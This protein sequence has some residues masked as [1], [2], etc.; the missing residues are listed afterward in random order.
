MVYFNFDRAQIWRIRLI[1]TDSVL[2]FEPAARKTARENF[3]RS[4]LS[5]LTQQIKI[6]NFDAYQNS[7]LC[8]NDNWIGST[9]VYFD[10]D[11]V[12][13]A[14]AY[15]GAAQILEFAQNADYELLKM[16]VDK[17]VKKTAKQ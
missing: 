2:I 15:R 7:P 12:L 17:L 10:K 14:E 4:E 9:S 13:I 11:K 5:L 1:Y 3:K 6:K 16:T 8:G